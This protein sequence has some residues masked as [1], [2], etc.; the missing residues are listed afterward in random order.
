M[1]KIEIRLA[2]LQAEIRNFYDATKWHFITTNGIDL[3]DNKLEIQWIFSQYETKD[4]TVI[5]YTI[6]NFETTIPSIVSLI[7]SAIMS[8]RELVD[9]FGVSVEG[10]QK[11][12]Y[13][14]EDSLTMPLRCSL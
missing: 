7:P 13:L 14:D 3:G 4:K 2:N 1:K 5:F 6:S 8:E 11:G 9:M 12:L 10:A